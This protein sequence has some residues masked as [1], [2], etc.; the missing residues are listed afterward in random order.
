MSKILRKWEFLTTIY[1]FFLTRQYNCMIALVFYWKL[2]FEIYEIVDIGYITMGVSLLILVRVVPRK[3]HAWSH[4][5][6]KSLK[7][8]GK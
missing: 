5:Y 1:L 4:K 6:Y 2:L 8:V 3:A 7:L